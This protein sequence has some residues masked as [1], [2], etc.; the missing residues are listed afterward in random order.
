MIADKSG[1]I[2]GGMDTAR[3]PTTDANRAART[4]TAALKLTQHALDTDRVGDLREVL[5][6]IGVRAVVPGGGLR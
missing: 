3:V 6:A 5:D 2:S 4:R 1:S